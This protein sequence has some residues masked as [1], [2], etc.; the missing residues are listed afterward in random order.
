MNQS[1]PM[2][3]LTSRN[4]TEAH[5]F[6]QGLRCTFIRKR[7]KSSNSHHG[8]AEMRGRTGLRESTS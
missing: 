6:G 5:Q 3:L 2:Q 7:W 8:L 4:T 1:Q